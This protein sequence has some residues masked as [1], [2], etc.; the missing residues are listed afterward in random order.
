MRTLGLE[1]GSRVGKGCSAVEPVAVAGACGDARNQTRKVA[2]AFGFQANEPAALDHHVHRFS[3]RRPNP[4]VNAGIRDLGSDGTASLLG[5]RPH[6]RSGLSKRVTLAGLASR[7]T[8]SESG[9]SS[10]AE[11]GSEYLAFGSRAG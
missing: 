10:T 7:A 2:G 11:P 8:T 9:T 5:R 3:D 1:A 4:E 6:W